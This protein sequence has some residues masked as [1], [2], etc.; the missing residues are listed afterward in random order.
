[1]LKLGLIFLGSGLGGLLRYGMQGGIQRFAG[2]S[3]PAGTMGV[4][5]IGCFVIGVLAAA[6]A[7]PVLIREEYRFGL[8]V[9][10]LGGFTT[11]SSFGLETL[12]LLN[13]GQWRLAA[14][15]VLASCALG[16][17]AVWGGYRLAESWFGV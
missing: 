4:N 11:F 14:V 13:D 3:F 5:V 12:M 15:N 10:L 8:M 6:F 7:G 9:G 17:L 16:F 2:G 1:M